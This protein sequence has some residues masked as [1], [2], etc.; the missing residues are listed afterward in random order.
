MKL[1]NRDRF[2]LDTPC[3]CRM[4]LA[5]LRACT[6]TR[7]AGGGRGEVCFSGDIPFDG[8]EFEL[9][10]LCAGRNSWLPI[11]RCTIAPAEAGSVLT[12]DARCWWLTRVFMAVW[13]G[14]LVFFTLVT[15]LEGLLHGF[16]WAMLAVPV[17]WGWGFG[18]SHVCFWRPMNRA[19]RDLCRILNGEIRAG[20]KD[21]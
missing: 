6:L 11:L 13:Y 21:T 19:R 15:L 18:L 1:R 7:Q 10:P 4:V 14:F 20:S 9:Q 17:M 12:V 16:A 5:T 3:D 2:F 8:T